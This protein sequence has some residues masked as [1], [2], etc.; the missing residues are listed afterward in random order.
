[1]I[2]NQQNAS[3]PFRYAKAKSGVGDACDVLHLVERFREADRTQEFPGQCR[4]SP[5]ILLQ[6]RSCANILQL[7]PTG[8]CAQR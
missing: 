2:R 4:L 8:I 3:I 7:S 1:M 5:A 6:I